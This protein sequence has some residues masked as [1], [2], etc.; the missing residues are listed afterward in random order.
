VGGFDMV[1][2]RHGFYKV[3]FHLP[4]DF[5]KVVSRGPWILFDHYLAVRAGAGI[6]VSVESTLVWIRFHA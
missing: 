1:D 5:E 3:K 6:E 4:Q 2:I